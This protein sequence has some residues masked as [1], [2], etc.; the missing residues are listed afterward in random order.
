MFRIKSIQLRIIL[1]AMLAVIPAV[2]LIITFAVISIR[3]TA[4]DAAKQGA[5]EANS[6]AGVIRSKIE[7]ALDN[8]RTMAQ[9]LTAVKS[10]E[11]SIT[12]SRD[13]ANAMFRQL[14]TINTNFVGTYTLWE[15][16]AFDGLDAE[17][18]GKALYDQT[19]RFITYWNRN[20]QGQIINAAP[21][22]TRPKVWKYLCPK[23]TRQ[24][25][26]TDLVSGSKQRC[27][28]DSIVT[29]YS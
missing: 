10:S 1:W 14:T 26:I 18:A 21:M 17:Y 25:C 13:Q 9:A 8:A 20:D 27:A 23:M 2:V 6:Q 28:D 7:V 29:P 22:T 5:E 3:T 11:G 15:P 4:I 12:L 19:G 16:N 24:E